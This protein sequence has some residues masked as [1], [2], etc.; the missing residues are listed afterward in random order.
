MTTA[1]V[2][3]APDPA[4][5]DITGA[6]AIASAAVVQ[7]RAENGATLPEPTNLLSPAPR[8]WTG[9]FADEDL[10]RAYRASMIR[11]HLIL[12]TIRFTLA[13]MVAISIQTCVRLVDRGVGSAGSALIVVP[14]VNVALCAACSAYCAIARRLDLSL[15]SIEAVITSLLCLLS[16]GLQL[17][18]RLD[19]LLETGLPSGPVQENGTLFAMRY[20]LM[21]LFAGLYTSMRLPLFVTVSAFAL[22]GAAAAEFALGARDAITVFT[23]ALVTLLVCLGRAKIITAERGQFVFSRSVHDAFRARDL[24]QQDRAAQAVELAKVSAAKEARTKLI[25]IVLHDLRSPLMAVHNVAESVAELI[26]P[27]KG[28]GSPS[29]PLEIGPGQFEQIAEDCYTLKSCVTLMEGI[30]SDMLDYERIDSG[31]LTLVYRPLQLANVVSA[32]MRTFQGRAASKGIR[33]HAEPIPGA[34]RE[35]WHL[36]DERRLLQCLNNGLSNALKFTPPG[37]TVAVT[38]RHD[39]DA[40]EG[41]DAAA[42]AVRISVHD[43]GAGLTADEVERLNRGDAFTQVGAGQLQGNSGTG[44]GLGI[45]QEMLRLHGNGSLGL[46]SAGRGAGTTFEMRLRLARTTAAG[47]GVAM[48][49]VDAGRADRVALRPRLPPIGSPAIAPPGEVAPGIPAV[50]APAPPR[51]VA[52]AAAERALSGVPPTLRSDAPFPTGTSTGGHGLP[53]CLH[54]EDDTFLQRTFPRR[55]FLKVGVAFDQVGD[56]QTALERMARERYDVVLI[57]NQMPVMPGAEA[58]RRMVAS[59]YTGIIVGVTGDPPGCEEH[60]AFLASGLSVLLGKDST[61]IRCVVDLLQHLKDHGSI[62][63]ES[64]QRLASSYGFAVGATSAGPD[65]AGLGRDQL[66]GD[67]TAK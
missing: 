44:I 21:L 53:R 20:T 51:A 45:V 1:Q 55:T 56:G 61:G 29:T 57:D 28:D 32:A 35:R 43:T 49:V 63:R 26:A 62:D 3:A 39:E 15:A 19:R 46:L 23:Y 31:R 58:V 41:G 38:V 27:A 54:V 50:L 52:P 8:K 2:S 37:G 34:M 22:A 40:T 11:P 9:S 10:E 25:R 17:P 30:V 4:L 67:F 42:D 48:A 24:V 59:G 13:F 18:E 12:S 66:P 64:A 33:L 16:I 60:A 47:D 5:E 36:G 65:G 14:I 7:D 6:P